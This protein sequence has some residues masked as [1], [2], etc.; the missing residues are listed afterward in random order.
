MT[1]NNSD[2]K[3]GIQ[4]IETPCKSS[5]WLMI[6]HLPPDGIRNKV[7]VLWYLNAC[8][9]VFR[10]DRFQ[11]FQHRINARHD[12]RQCRLDTLDATIHTGKFSTWSDVGYSRHLRHEDSFKKIRDRIQL[13]VDVEITSNFLQEI[14]T[15]R[16]FA[17]E[18][19]FKHCTLSHRECGHP[20]HLCHATFADF[21]MISTTAGSWIRP[22]RRRDWRGRI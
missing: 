3:V 12:S 18:G 16:M 9:I 1:G 21:E 4:A 19:R 11:A 2:R 14:V 13:P 10:L 22:R 15:T 8:D 17:L 6:V 7:K 20:R 5:L